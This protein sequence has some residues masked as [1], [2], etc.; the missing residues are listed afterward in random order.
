MEV[1]LLLFAC[2]GIVYEAIQ[3]LFFKTVSVEASI[4]SFLVMGVA[5]GVNIPLARRLAGWQRN[6]TARPWKQR[7]WIF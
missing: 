7:G 5:I 6:M 3:R 1:L 2:A 4:W